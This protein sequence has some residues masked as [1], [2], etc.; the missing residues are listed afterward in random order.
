MPRMRAFALAVAL[1]AALTPLAR[2]DRQQ[3]PGLREVIAA[4]IKETPCFAAK[5]DDVVWFALMQPR[6]EARLRA[7]PPDLRL[8]D[9]IQKAAERILHA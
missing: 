9:D 8:G 6:V 3:D 4:A 5:Y 1:F 2:A 7:Q